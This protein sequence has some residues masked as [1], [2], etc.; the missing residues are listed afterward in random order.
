MRQKITGK[1]SMEGHETNTSKHTHGCNYQK[2]FKRMNNTKS[3]SMKLQSSS[4]LP[5]ENNKKHN[6]KTEGQTITIEVR[7]RRHYNNENDEETDSLSS[8]ENTHEK[9]HD[10][11]NT[12]LD[13]KNG[14]QIP[15]VAENHP[16]QNNIDFTYR[17]VERIEIPQPTSYRELQIA[18]ATAF[19]FLD[20]SIFSRLLWN[21]PYLG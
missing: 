8:A 11:N 19:P 3:I 10:L 12:D 1:V 17:R 2:R 14:N 21:L 15:L 7:T 5:S 9:E 13:D 16:L 6:K 18:F 4:P 20:V